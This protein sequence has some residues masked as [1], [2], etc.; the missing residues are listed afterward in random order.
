MELKYQTGLS[1]ETVSGYL[2]E[3][4]PSKNCVILHLVDLTDLSEESIIPK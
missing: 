4:L 3:V 1:A 2:S